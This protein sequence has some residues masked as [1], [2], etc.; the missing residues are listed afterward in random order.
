MLRGEAEL[1][2]KHDKELFGHKFRE[3]LTETSKSKKR[4]LEAFSTVAQKSRP[5]EM[6]PCNNNSKEVVEG[7][8]SFS[9]GESYFVFRISKTSTN[10][11]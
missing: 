4:A 5:F 7:N 11:P 3:H 9:T 2:Q 1:L 8:K 10:K 6:A